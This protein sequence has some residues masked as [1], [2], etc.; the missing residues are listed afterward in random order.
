MRGLVVALALLAWAAPVDAQDRVRGLLSLPEVFGNGP[1]HPFEP[2]VVDLYAAPGAGAR[3]AA[4]QVEQHWAFA[5]HGG[6]EGLKVGV[7]RDGRR[8]ELPT[9][10]Y[11]SETPA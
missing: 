9:L 7:H 11:S 5:P 10:E 4:I 1:C 3:I 6:C 8:S 2:E